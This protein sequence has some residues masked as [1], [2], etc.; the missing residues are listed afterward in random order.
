MNRRLFISSSLALGGVAL[1]SRLPSWANGNALE[2]SG[3]ADADP[4]PSPQPKGEGTRSKGI[5]KVIKT[6]AEWKSQ[7]NAGAVQRFAAGRH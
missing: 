1:L 7:L 5:K 6:D 4:R 2:L 3:V